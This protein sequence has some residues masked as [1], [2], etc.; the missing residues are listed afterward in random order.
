MYNYLD[1][2]G[3]TA[4]IYFPL[5]VIVGSFFL[6]KLFLAVIMQTFSEMS[7]K[8]LALDISTTIEHYEDRTIKHMILVAKKKLRINHGPRSLNEAALLIYGQAKKEL[9]KRRKMAK[10][11]E[12]RRLREQQTLKDD[13]TPTSAKIRE[14]QRKLV[15]AV[16]PA[17]IQ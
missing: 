4:G 6:L 5:C 2:V 11:E 15:T 12:Q 9:E 17:V 13:E 1:S 16:A 3:I 14:M 7:M 8:N 10:L